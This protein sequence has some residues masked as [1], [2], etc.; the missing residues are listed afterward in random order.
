[1]ASGAPRLPEERLGPWI[2]VAAA[3]H[4]GVFLSFFIL[5]AVYDAAPPRRLID[6]ADAMEVALVA[7]P[8]SEGL[9]QLATRRALPKA[10]EAKPDAA[11]PPSEA[12]P[13][14]PPQRV[15]DLAVHTEKPDPTPATEPKPDAP[16][17]PKGVDPASQRRMADLMADLEREALLSDL[18]AKEGPKDRDATS[19]DGVEGAPASSRGGN[20]TGDPEFAAYIRKL[21]D[22]FDAR[23]RPLPALRG[24]GLRTEILVSVDAQGKVTGHRVVTSS[25]N[26]SW[27]NAAESAVREV[28]SLPLPPDRFRDRMRDGY[29]IT[30]EDR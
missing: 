14:P 26:P 19:P 1:M 27:D 15:S 13:E 10:P 16:A 7:M 25:D 3:G 6:P 12:K 11:P 4:V 28:T 20:P 29:K 17:K 18:D 23:F 30:F 5:Q 2:G 21:A 8:K 24:K 9:P 22:L